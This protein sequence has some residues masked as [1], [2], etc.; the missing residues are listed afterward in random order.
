MRFFGFSVAISFWLLSFSNT[1]LRFTCL[2][3]IHRS[4]MIEGGFGGNLGSLSTITRL[5]YLALII[6]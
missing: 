2:Y 1:T 4:I 6:F 3:G 5:K